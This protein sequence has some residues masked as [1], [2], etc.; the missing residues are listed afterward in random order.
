MRVKKRRIKKG[1]IIKLIIVSTLVIAI[2]IGIKKIIYLNS[3]EYK[4]KE[5]G[6][7]E[8]QIAEILKLDKTYKKLSIKNEKKFQNTKKLRSPPENFS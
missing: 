5:I 8:S 1:P 2:I 3:D 7:N 4:L 6:Y